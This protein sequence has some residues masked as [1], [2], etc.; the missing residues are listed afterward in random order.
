MISRSLVQLFPVL[1]HGYSLLCSL[2]T[3]FIAARALGLEAFGSYV[4]VTTLSMTLG[5]V[6]TDGLVRVIARR[7]P[8]R[9]S[10][11]EATATTIASCLIA[12]GCLSCTL[13]VFFV[14]G[15]WLGG[16]HG[17]IDDSIAIATAA[18]SV[19]LICVCSIGSSIRFAKRE[20]VAASAPV[21]VVRPTLLLGA[22]SGL[23]LAGSVEIRELLI[24]FTASY[25]CAALLSAGLMATRDRHT[26]KTSRRGLRRRA[27]R[28][29]SYAGPFWAYATLT[30][31]RERATL[32]LFG[33]IGAPA[34][35][36]LFS[37]ATRISVGLQGFL[38]VNAASFQ[39]RFSP[40][41]GEAATT[42]TTRVYD[43][44]LR[45][46]VLVV[47]PIACL[48]LGA[49]GLVGILFGEEFLPAQG[50]VR[51]LMLSIL[52][53]LYLAPISGVLGMNNQQRWL[54][55]P[56]AIALAASITL[57]VILGPTLG[58]MGA[59]L[60]LLLPQVALHIAHYMRLRA[61][62]SAALLSKRN[63]AASVAIFVVATVIGS[64]GVTRAL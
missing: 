51:V 44:M 50:A 48:F 58:A 40:S 56:S 30:S 25:A 2:L 55:K 53:T 59:A 20:L 37:A 61:L 41:H 29:F 18:V 47:L 31:I 11:L 1:A 34:D 64:L 39:P 9:L 33:A 43:A 4:V 52:F 36:S 14:V 8:Q 15:A 13:T 60:A 7:V 49:P 46:R 24:A 54:A 27:W 42:Q 38:N 45:Q 16:M 22:T 10:S 6:A 21:S 17:W 26:L 12:A 35:V 57:V 19:P 32:M 5:G 28:Y 63:L 3:M 62:M 23:W